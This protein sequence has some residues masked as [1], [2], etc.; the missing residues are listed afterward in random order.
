MKTQKSNPINSPIVKVDMEDDVLGKANKDGSIGRD[1]SAS[2]AG[3]M[4]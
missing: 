4:I 2:R 1:T 3:K